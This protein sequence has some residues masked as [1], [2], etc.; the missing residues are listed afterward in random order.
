M[1]EGHVSLMKAAESMG[2]SERQAC[3]LMVRFKQSGAAGLAHGNRDRPA[4]NRL[5]AATR[6][7]ILELVNRRGFHCDASASPTFAHNLD[8]IGTAG[9]S[10][11]N[12]TLLLGS[13]SD[14]FARL[15]QHVDPRGRGRFLGSRLSDERIRVLCFVPDAQNLSPM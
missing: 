9:M 7:R 3:G 10:K 6:Q 8:P 1:A 2:V 13:Y 12:Q 4:S 15:R 14:T 5:L 11:R